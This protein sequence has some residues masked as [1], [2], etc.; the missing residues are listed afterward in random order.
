MNPSD[1][2]KIIDWHKEV[3][4]LL[5]KEV[6]KPSVE[7]VE[8]NWTYMQQL[9]EGKQFHM[10]SDISKAPPPSGK[11]RV[12]VKEVFQEMEPYLASSQVYVGKNFLLQIALKFISASMGMK[13]FNVV[14]SIEVAV[15][16]IKNEH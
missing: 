2:V 13:Q 6:P 14:K 1:Y 3:P 7:S 15:E 16:K 9:T 12:A 10:I 11:V 4:I 8:N 5:V